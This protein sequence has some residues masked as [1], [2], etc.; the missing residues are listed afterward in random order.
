[1][2]F[3]CSS[4][5]GTPRAFDGGNNVFSLFSTS[6]H[7]ISLFCAP[8][9]S[10]PNPQKEKGNEAVFVWMALKQTEGDSGKCN[11]RGAQNII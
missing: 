3:L 1:M 6:T 8:S 11:T 9:A 5:S 10:L 2:G 7:A 4:P